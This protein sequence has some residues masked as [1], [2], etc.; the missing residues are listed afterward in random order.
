MNPAMSLEMEAAAQHVRERCLF[1]QDSLFFQGSAVWTPA[2]LKRLRTVFLEQPDESKRTF[3][4][5]Y[6]DQLANEDR[7][8]ILLGAEVLAVYY[9]YPL[10][11]L[12]DTKRDR[13]NQVLRWAGDELPEDNPIT[14]AF[15]HGII[16]AGQG[17]NAHRPWEMG[18][19][20]DFMLAW[21]ESAP[22]DRTPLLD[23]HPWEFQ[24]FVDQVDNAGTTQMRHILL[25]LF[26]PNYF[27]QIA[28][29]GHKRALVTTFGGL[30]TDKQ[31][32]GRVL[33]HRPLKGRPVPTGAHT[34]DE[35]DPPTGL[36][37]HEALRGKPAG[38]RR[39]GQQQHPGGGA[40]VRC[41]VH[42]RLGCLRHGRQP[43]PTARPER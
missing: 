36:T 23:G 18:F 40:Q 22:E 16:N 15:W 14:R 5:K 35:C 7:E 8:V 33:S 21:H 11:V 4:E 3:W 12:G 28:S 20:I 9:L 10:N 42:S 27:E 41:S 26:Y 19:L 29:T 2:N 13:V 25:A 38:R 32:T 6:Q 31:R 17:Y 30:L 39:L 1:Q 24:D 37:D 43:P 34:S